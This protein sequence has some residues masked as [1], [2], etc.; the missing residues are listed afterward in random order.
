MRAAVL[1]LAMVMSAVAGSLA[2][3]RPATEAPSVTFHVPESVR[4]KLE[5]RYLLV[6]LGEGPG[7]IET[8]F[9]PG[10]YAVGTTRINAK[11]ARS[12][13]AWA[14]LPGD[15]HWLVDLDLTTGPATRTVALEFTPLRQVTLSGR[16][17][18]PENAVPRSA[19]VSAE[20]LPD[21]Y[22]EFFGLTECML[23][24]VAVA[25]ASATDDGK[26]TLD[27]PDFARDPALTRFTRKGRF[28]LVARD[29][30]DNTRFW[31]DTGDPIGLWVAESYPEL[32]LI[33]KAR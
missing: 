30:G 5:I 23:P 29:Q 10:D 15:G 18:W 8:K 11:S 25:S 3:Q 2:R 24:S 26:F 6:G 7:I 22:C 1:T 14:Y 27:V 33:P 17:V 19:R 20:Y 21:S 32:R 13:K 12:L 31:L 28:R 4:S 16:I 9:G